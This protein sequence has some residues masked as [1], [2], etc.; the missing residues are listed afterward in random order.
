MENNKKKRIADFKIPIDTSKW[1]IIQVL[2]II[3][4]KTSPKDAESLMESFAKKYEILLQEHE[5][6]DKTDLSRYYRLITEFKPALAY[7]LKPGKK[8]DGMCDMAVNQFN[9]AL[10][11]IRRQINDE[12]GSIQKKGPILPGSSK[13]IDLNYFCTICKQEFEIPSDIKTQLLNSSQ[14]MELPKH[15]E[16]EMEIRIKR[17]KKEESITKNES[18]DEKIEIYPAELLMGQI[19]S[20]ESNVEYFAFWNL[21]LSLKLRMFL[22]C[23]N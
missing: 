13:K 21:R 3:L 4:M 19:D 9:V 18:E 22:G 23:W 15:H 20:T 11:R 14:K 12:K 2:K 10:N 6:E 17:P 5:Q 8:F 7:I 16:K 1:G